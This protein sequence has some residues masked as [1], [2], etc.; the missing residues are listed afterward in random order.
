[1]NTVCNTNEQQYTYCVGQK[2]TK[3]M[4]RYKQWL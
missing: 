1:M 3:Q 4:L 2:G